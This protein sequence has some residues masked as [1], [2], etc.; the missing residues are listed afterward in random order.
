MSLPKHTV[1][2]FYTESPFVVDADDNVDRAQKLMSSKGIRHLPVMSDG[3]LLGVLSDRD[4]KTAMG[5]KGANSK[6]LRCGDLCSESVYVTHRDSPLAA[7]ANELATKHY[8]SAVV[9][10]RD[11]VVGIFTTT[12]ACRALSSVLTNG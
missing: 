7:V 9:T 2:D 4:I 6:R 1:E 3:K 12:D 10:E 11:E 8:G 5:F